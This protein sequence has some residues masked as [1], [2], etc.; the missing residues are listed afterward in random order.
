MNTD[1]ARSTPYAHDNFIL[2]F[3]IAVR[4]DAPETEG[5]YAFVN[6][7]GFGY[8]IYHFIVTATMGQRVLGCS[9]KD[10]FL[11]SDHVPLKIRLNL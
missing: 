2:Y 4:I 1:L 7:N 5:T 3:N 10:N 6:P 9:I 8:I 11:Y